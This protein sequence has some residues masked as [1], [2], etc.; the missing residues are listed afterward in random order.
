MQHNMSSIVL[1]GSGPENKTTQ[2]DSTGIEVPQ[3]FHR[4]QTVGQCGTSVPAFTVENMCK[5]LPCTRDFVYKE[6]AVGKNFQGC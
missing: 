1:L 4:F 5:C 2:P 3:T 6:R